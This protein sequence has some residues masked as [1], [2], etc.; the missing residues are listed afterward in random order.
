MENDT[1]DELRFEITFFAPFRV[2]TG[3]AAQGVDA[4]VD[5][6]NPLPGASLKG[7]MLSA[8]RDVLE[9]RRDA[10]DKVFGSHAKQSPWAFNDAIVCK[11]GS[12]VGADQV[13]Q[14]HRVAID[15][16]THTAR[17]NYLLL[18]EVIHADRAEFTVERI[19]YLPPD[20]SAR[21]KL[22]LT[23]AARAVHS[24]GAQR[25][26]GLGWVGITGGADLCGHFQEL[27]ELRRPACS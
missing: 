7:L 25:R 27:L 9:L 8:A 18:G 19:R 10:L 5:L 11:N 1:D 20:E 3:T 4:A 13:A 12:V 23:A 15:A 22:I 21:H 24:L 6:G 2:A 26:R 16:A 14:R 17:E